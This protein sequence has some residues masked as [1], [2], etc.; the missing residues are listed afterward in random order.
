MNV[1]SLPVIR[2]E[3]EVKIMKETRRS[4]KAT[5][6]ETGVC[7]YLTWPIVQDTGAPT[8]HGKPGSLTCPL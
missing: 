1:W 4:G 2:L 7:V 3:Q 8:T 5:T 6:A